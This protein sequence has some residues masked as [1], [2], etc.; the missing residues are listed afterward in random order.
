MWEPK[1]GANELAQESG[2]V[3]EQRCTAELTGHEVLRGERRP[4]APQLSSR[5]CSSVEKGGAV[6]FVGVDWAEDH[7][8]I[9]VMKQ[10]GA[11][12]GKRRVPDSVAGIGELH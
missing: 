6:I 5:S 11:V 10:D 4:R 12:F 8:D 1:R 9:C 3:L 7:H 2:P